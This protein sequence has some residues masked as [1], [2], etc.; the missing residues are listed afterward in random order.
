MY[1][2]YSF[3]P[4]GPRQ[5]LAPLQLGLFTRG[6]RDVELVNVG[7][8]LYLP[9]SSILGLFFPMQSCLFHD[10]PLDVGRGV[11]T[12]CV[13]CPF[14]L[15]LLPCHHSKSFHAKSFFPTSGPLATCSCSCHIWRRMKVDHRS[16][17]YLWSCTLHILS[18]LWFHS[19]HVSRVFRGYPPLSRRI[20][21]CT[22]L[23]ACKSAVW[24]GHV[25]H[26]HRAEGLIRTS[27]MLAL[28]LSVPLP[29]KVALLPVRAALAFC[30][31]AAMTMDT[32]DPMV[33]V[34]PSTLMTWFGP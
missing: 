33:K 6:P 31:N 5:G 32:E 29:W 18:D 25:P 2:P 27:D 1:D 21:S 23:A 12:S 28:W 3:S 24:H 13:S 26:P 7:P 17:L 8:D 22:V 14:S 15:F 16:C 4:G 9:P 20:R 34:V 11:K 19:A 30:C 10:A